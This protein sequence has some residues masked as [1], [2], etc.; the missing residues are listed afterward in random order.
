[1]KILLRTLVV[2]AS[3][4]PLAC[5]AADSP[6][7]YQ[8]GEHYQRVRAVQPPANPAKIEVMEVFAYSCPHCYALEP[9]LKK[10]LAKKPGDVE[11]VRTPHTLGQP[12]N[13]TRNRAFYAAQMLGVLDK[14]H[15]ALFDA[16]HRDRKNPATP[17]E[18]RE[19]AVRAGIKGEDFD[20]A[21]NGFAADAGYRRGEQTVQ[22]L[23]I[24]S[25]PTLVVEGRYSVSPNLAGG[26]DGM[27]KVTDFL[28]EQARRER[29][30]R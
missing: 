18:L 23:G 11:F 15:P 5:T 4:S 8:L 1:M 2:L 29:A 22:A 16:I 3:L 12:A 26:F 25:V 24:T 13:Q 21:M 30:K 27:L 17:A 20:G 7:Q 9:A 19:L 14:F 6:Q 28:I 10:W